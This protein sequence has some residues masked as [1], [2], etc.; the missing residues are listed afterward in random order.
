LWQTQHVVKLLRSAEPDLE[1]EV[2][3]LETTADQRLDL[4]IVDIG[5]KGAFCKEIQSLVLEGHADLAV[6][7]AK[8]LQAETP[9]GL[10]LGAVPERGDVRDALVGC[11]LADLRH[12]AL[13][14]TGSQRR[15]VQLAELRPDLGFTELRGNIGTRLSRLGEFDAI[16]MAS[17]ALERLDLHPDV[18]DVLE[19]EVMLPQ[20][21]QG[22]LAIECRDN[23]ETALEVL[24]RIN[25]QPSRTIVD[26]ER[27]FL[28]ELGGDC[29]LPAGAHARLAGDDVVVVGVLAAD[30][31]RP[32]SLQRAAVTAPAADQPGRTLARRLRSRLR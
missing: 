24:G 4:R 27:D 28:I 8:D 6:H 9:S 18:V 16:V 31:D 22:A 20:V 12:G 32:E 23:D 30:G 25:H 17:V 5:G 14:A 19:P 2:I 29:D 3:D 7:S 1:V 26:A 11:R 10:R 13:V 15:R 21:G